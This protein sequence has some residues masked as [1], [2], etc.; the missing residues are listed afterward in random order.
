MDMTSSRK[1]HPQRPL[2]VVCIFVNDAFSAVCDVHDAHFVH[3]G[4]VNSSKK[5]DVPSA[6]PTA[7]FPMFS[8]THGLTPTPQ[9]KTPYDPPKALETNI[10][11]PTVTTPLPP[12]SPPLLASMRRVDYFHFIHSS[13]SKSRFL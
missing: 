1:R 10:S 7:L 12:L 4:Y 5:A 3:L 13:K 6:H 9:P 2:F 11:G 8:N